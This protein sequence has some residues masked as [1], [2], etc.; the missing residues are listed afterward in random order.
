MEINLEQI[1][2]NKSINELLEFS[3]INIDKPSGPTSFSVS[4]FVKNSLKLRKTSHFGTLDP[5]VSGVLPVALNRASRLNDYFIDKDKTYVGIMR[6]H[7]TIPEKKLKEVI[8]KFIGKIKQIPPLRSRVKREIREREVKSFDILEIDNKDV[9]F[10]TQVQAGT[11]IRKLCDDI[12]KEIGGAHMLE[13]RRIKAGIF[14]ENKSV[15][16]YDFERAVEEYNNGNE[17]FLRK[18]LIPAEI[19][20]TILKTIQVRKSSL[21]SLLRGK[22]IFKEDFENE[23]E[24]TSLNYG[25]KIAIFYQNRFIEVARI[26]NEKKIIARPEFVFN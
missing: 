26:T 24:I 23:R 7:K 25:E 6:L 11:Y 8:K 18:I 10:L 12:G 15:N 4:Q 20:G 16:L 21:P 2:E 9:L 1:K 3:L 22:P 19:I 5:Q 14:D 13:L 17:T